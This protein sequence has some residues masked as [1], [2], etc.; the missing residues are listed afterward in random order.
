MNSPNCLRSGHAFSLKNNEYRYGSCPKRKRLT[1]KNVILQNVLWP[2][3]SSLPLA[4][5]SFGAPP[6][7]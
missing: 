6:Y 7:T 3:F 4:A 1:V 5:A 2:H